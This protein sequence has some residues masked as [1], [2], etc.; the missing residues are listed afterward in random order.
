MAGAPKDQQ[1]LLAALQ[2]GCELSPLQFFVT[3]LIGGF[4]AGRK[5]VIWN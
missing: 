5:L 3:A 2:L 4:I 1:A